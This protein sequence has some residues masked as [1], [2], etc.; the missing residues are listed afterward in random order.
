MS[1]GLF[2]AQAI[3]QG[4]RGTRRLRIQAMLYHMV[5]TIIV[6][7]LAFALI[8]LVWYPGFFWT[9]AAGSELFVLICVIDIVLGPLLT[10]AVFNPAKGTRRLQSDLL[11]IVIVQLAALSYGLWTVATV[12]PLFLVYTVDRFNLVTASE[13]TK[14]QLRSAELTQFRE[15]RWLDPQII[16]SREPI[17][18]D[19]KFEFIDS[20]LSGRDRHLFPKTYVPFK[21]VAGQMLDH[22]RPLA[23]LK[24][25]T[26]KQ[27]A[28]VAA[29]QNRFAVD[30]PR[31]GFLPVV[32]Q[33][34][35]VMVVDRA[36]GEL[37]DVLPIDGLK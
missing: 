20:A 5:G 15:L 22:A 18:G 12:R 9:I 25:V 10:F 27:A 36:T 17:S 4:Q 3:Q 11:F 34:D 29:V 30:H 1:S 13:I 32:A 26:T 21:Q 7:T 19:E 14:D 6:A 31:L 35:W 2:L 28:V 24:S 8:R 16:G 33:G 37:L 23:N